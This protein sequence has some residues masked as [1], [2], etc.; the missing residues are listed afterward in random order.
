MS[1]TV[2]R[3]VEHPHLNNGRDD[4]LIE[5][6]YHFRF[7]YPSLPVLCC[8]LLFLQTLSIL[9][10]RGA[11]KGLD[12]GHSADVRGSLCKACPRR[13]SQ[14]D[15]HAHLSTDWRVPSLFLSIPFF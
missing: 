6:I 4:I 3:R 9:V 12:I 8:T 13:V 11:L 10:S 15:F 2:L 5:P 14:Q 7:T 1:C